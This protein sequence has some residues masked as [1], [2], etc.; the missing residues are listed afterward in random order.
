SRIFFSRAIIVERCLGQRHYFQN[1]QGLIFVVDSNQR[2]CT[3]EA[4]DELHKMLNERRCAPSF[5]KQEKSPNAMNAAEITDKLDFHSLRQRI[6]RALEP[7]LVKGFM[8]D[9]T[10][11]QTTLQTRA[12]DL[13]TRVQEIEFTIAT[14][15]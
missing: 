10:G 1:T 12:R 7:H 15:I 14:T 2:D 6:S 9:W 8:K 13:Q 3:V 4:R 5:R 11:S